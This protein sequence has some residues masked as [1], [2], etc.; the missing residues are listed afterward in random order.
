M[1]FDELKTL[2]KTLVDEKGL[3]W[4]DDQMKA[5]ANTAMRTVFRQIAGF[6]ATHF[7]TTSTITYP[8]DTEYIDLTSGSYFNITPSVYKVLAVSKL[9]EAAAVTPTNRPVQLDRTDAASPIGY[10]DSWNDPNS[11]ARGLSTTRRWFLDTSNLYLVPIPGDATPLLVRWVNQPT[12]LNSGSDVVFAGKAFEYHDL[13][14]TTLARLM[15]VKERRMADEI[16]AINDWLR[17]ELQQAERSRSQHPQVR[18]ES[19]Y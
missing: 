7:A 19:P 16:V 2:A 11:E 12:D 17:M 3:F 15:V 18:Y 8:A 9:N 5:L 10:A 14:A 1:T 6:D 4:S 13:V